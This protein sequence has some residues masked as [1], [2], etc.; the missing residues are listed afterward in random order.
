V[1]YRALREHEFANTKAT[2]KG[3]SLGA[4]LRFNLDERPLIKR[5]LRKHGLSKRWLDRCASCASTAP[6][7]SGFFENGH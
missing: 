5:K 2:L 4:S 7:I 1:R 6:T 3:D